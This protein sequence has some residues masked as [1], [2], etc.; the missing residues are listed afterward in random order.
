MADSRPH[1]TRYSRINIANIEVLKESQ[2]FTEALQPFRGNIDNLYTNTL[3]FLNH[4]NDC[5][6]DDMGITVTLDPEI[7][8]FDSDEDI[9][10]NRPGIGYPTGDAIN[11][12]L[13][14]NKSRKYSV[15]YN[16]NGTIYNFD[17]NGG[18]NEIYYRDEEDENK[19]KN[20]IK[21]YFQ[22]IIALLK[23]NNKLNEYTVEIWGT[24][25]VSIPRD[26]KFIFYLNK[27]LVRTSYK[28]NEIDDHTCAY[29]RK[30][31]EEYKNHGHFN[32]SSG[33]TQAS[34]F[35]GYFIVTRKEGM[36]GLIAHELCH[37]I[38]ADGSFG[39]SM[40]TY[41]YMLVN[42]G[43][44]IEKSNYNSKTDNLQEKV[45]CVCNTNATII[46]SMLTAIEMKE[47]DDGINLED[48][49]REILENEIIYCCLQ[50][51]RLLQFEGMKNFEDLF[52]E[53]IE[54][55]VNE[56]CSFKYN[57]ALYPYIALRYLLI[58]NYPAALGDTFNNA[59]TNNKRD[60][61]NILYTPANYFIGEEG[62]QLQEASIF[63]NDDYH[64]N[65]NQYKRLFDVIKPIN[66][67]LTNDS[68]PRDVTFDEL[69]NSS[70]D[71]L[72]DY[73]VYDFRPFE[74]ETN[75]IGHDDANNYFKKYLKYKTKYL[76]L[77]NK[78]I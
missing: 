58:L 71:I 61:E 28:P 24:T 42:I 54:N 59:G 72:I 43:D 63:G 69:D 1:L 10:N 8:S 44:I 52:K 3:K 14:A 40:A 37:L 48:K 26:V 30:F 12:D 67:K 77:K 5:Y 2:E 19:L 60:H 53:Q 50:F 29:G 74:N 62:R 47:L 11:S 35:P 21:F 23:I 51:V 4:L 25:E 56:N 41:Q 39:I 64:G 9:R 75:I 38:G 34:E 66:D 13:L 68:R 33:E 73:F 65:Y 22:R 55:E 32:N 45:E 46:H 70:G 15:E 18:G 76:S 78:L 27:G 49:Y 57:A 20:E 31:L 6:P 7:T 36:V 16:D 17:N